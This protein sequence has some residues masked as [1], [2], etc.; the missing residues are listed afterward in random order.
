MALVSYSA[1][2]SKGATVTA[3]LDKVALLALDSVTSDPWWADDA[4]IAQAIVTLKTNPGKGKIVLQFDFTQNP[5]TA[6]L[7]LPQFTRDEFQID[8]IVMIDTMGDKIV[9]P[10]A[11][12]LSEIPTLSESEISVGSGGSGDTVPPVPGPGGIVLAPTASSV[13]VEWDSA[14]DNVT[15]QP[16][17]QLVYSESAN[18]GTVSDAQANG[19]LA[20]DWA[21]DTSFHTVPGLSAG[22]QYYFNV[23]VRDEAGN[24]AAYNQETATTA[25][26]LS[27]PFGVM[28]SHVF[29][30]GDPIGLDGS[31]TAPVEGDTNNWSYN[32]Y[33]STTEP[34]SIA[35]AEFGLIVGTGTLFST[36]LP[37]LSDTAFLNPLYPDLGTY[38]YTLVVEALDGT[39]TGVKSASVEMVVVSD[40]IAPYAPTIVTSEI[41]YVVGL[42]SEAVVLTLGSS[43]ATDG[44][45]ISG[46]ITTITVLRSTTL[47]TSVAEALLGVIVDTI[48]PLY[49]AVNSS[50]PMGTVTDSTLAVGGFVPEGR[51]YYSVVAE[52]AA[53]NSSFTT[54]TFTRYFTGMAS[55]LVTG[56]VTSPVLGNNPGD[57]FADSYQYVILDGNT[58]ELTF[59]LRAINALPP[60]DNYMATINQEGDGYYRIQLPPGGWELGPSV[61]LTSGVTLGTGGGATVLGTNLGTIGSVEFSVYDYEGDG[62]GTGPNYFQ[63]TATL[64]AG[65]DSTSLLLR[66]ATNGI[67][68][69]PNTTDWWSSSFG[70]VAQGGGLDILF[71][72]VQ[73]PV[74]PA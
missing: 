18:I 43:Y 55:S 29:V 1:T 65:T 22:T 49:N 45:D 9:I 42:S 10:R 20:L 37:G 39:N 25:A 64:Y 16:E 63:G 60:V 57:W 62:P 27:N 32:W 14:S 6:Q 21:T 41:Q 34:T 15:L 70:K 26:A 2:P 53:G 66:V 72:S 52:D 56:S 23:L 38:Y 8:K 47:P 33:R 73:I 50:E 54:Q 71:L 40:T 48:N 74:V 68:S 30:P 36:S 67:S 17:Y 11:T 61:T 44:W 31:W 7:T 12:L 35:E 19:T 28:T 4:G 13:Y 46:G 51:Y 59:Q 69:E 3:T 58:M 24:I 5:S